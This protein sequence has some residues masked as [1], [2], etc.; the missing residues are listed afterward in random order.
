MRRVI[1]DYK[2]LTPEILSLLTQKFPDGYNDRDIVVF[3]NHHNEIIEAV[4]VNTKDTVYLVKVSS[5]L[6]YS[7]TNFDNDLEKLNVKDLN[8]SDETLND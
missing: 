5:K 7:M 2:K 8:L 3:D 6:H 1:I 4:E